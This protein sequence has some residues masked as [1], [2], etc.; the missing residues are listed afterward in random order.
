MHIAMGSPSSA[1]DSIADGYLTSRVFIT[2]V[3]SARIVD[4]PCTC[5]GGL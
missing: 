3:P 5:H 2:H 1:V 4:K